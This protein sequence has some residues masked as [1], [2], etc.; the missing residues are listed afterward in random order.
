VSDAEGGPS[1]ER[2]PFAPKGDVPEWRL[3]YDLL[4]DGAEFGD[5]ITYAELDQAL[6]R[7]FLDNRSPLYRAR[8]ELGDQRHRWLEA[9]PNVGYRVI[10]AAEHLRVAGQH[11]RRA[12]TQLGT[13][14]RVTLATDLDA[15]TP[16]ELQRF[17]AQA[18]I[19]AALVAIVTSHEQRLGRIEETLRKNGM[20]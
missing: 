7:R 19:N 1:G 14:Q 10:T 5:V 3:L 13:M 20:L 2:V 16:E 18:R 6:E 15:L 9:V 17:D 11:K 4:L 12:K 8:R